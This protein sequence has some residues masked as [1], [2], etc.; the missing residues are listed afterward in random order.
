MVQAARCADSGQVNSKLPVCSTAVPSHEGHNDEDGAWASRRRRTRLCHITH[1]LSLLQ[2]FACVCNITLLLLVCPSMACLRIPN[3]RSAVLLQSSPRQHTQSSG[4]L[5]PLV[6]LLLLLLLL[7]LPSRQIAFT[8]VFTPAHRLLAPRE[9]SRRRCSA[10]GPWYAC[11]PRGQGL[12]GFGRCE[13]TEL[14]CSQQHSDT[15]LTHL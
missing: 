1:M 6:L 10:S 9:Q 15:P 11:L 8:V 14:T 2:C 7:L 13:R 5:L 12:A 3:S 4:L